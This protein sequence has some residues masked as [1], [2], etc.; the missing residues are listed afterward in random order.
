MAETNPDI[1]GLNSV[2]ILAKC[3]LNKSRVFC[4][5]LTVADWKKGNKPTQS[6]GRD[7]T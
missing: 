5:T 6:K 3:C 7:S 1:N 4:L 2:P